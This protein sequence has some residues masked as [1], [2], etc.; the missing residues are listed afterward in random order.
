VC[1]RITKT[2]RF[3]SYVRATYCVCVHTSLNSFL[4]TVPTHKWVRIFKNFMSTRIAVVNV[5][6]SLLREGDSKECLRIQEILRDIA[7]CFSLAKR[8]IPGR[9]DRYGNSNN[10]WGRHIRRGVS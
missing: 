1:S 10:R 4:F 5:K 3:G 9:C 2:F 6:S 7:V 8:F